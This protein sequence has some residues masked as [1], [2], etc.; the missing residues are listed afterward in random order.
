MQYSQGRL[1]SSEEPG[2]GDPLLGRVPEVSHHHSSAGW[3][4][5][6]AQTVVSH[7]LWIIA[8]CGLASQ[9]ISNEVPSLSQFS[10]LRW[11]QYQCLSLELLEGFRAIRQASQPSSV[12]SCPPPHVRSPYLF[13]FPGD[14]LCRHMCRAVGESFIVRRGDSFLDGTRCVPSIPQED[15][16]LNLCVSGSCRVGVWTAHVPLQPLWPQGLPILLRGLVCGCRGQVWNTGDR[17]RRQVQGI[18]DQVFGCSGAG[19]GCREKGQGYRLQWHY[20]LV[21]R[22]VALEAG[23]N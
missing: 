7:R 17:G 16:T 9:Q 5:T 18:G 8:W 12:P 22:R 2:L 11:R 23:R 20:T 10:L 3:S 13:T 19:L 14:T 21:C 6:G 15:G 1:G 4:R